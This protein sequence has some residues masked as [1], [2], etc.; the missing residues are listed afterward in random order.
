MTWRRS[1]PANASLA[2]ADPVARISSSVDRAARRIRTGDYPDAA[3]AGIRIDSTPADRFF[4]FGGRS[5]FR[6]LRRFSR[7]P[8]S[9]ATPFP[10][11]GRLALRFLKSSS[12]NRL[13]YCHIVDPHIVEGRVGR[14]SRD[15]MDQGAADP[16]IIAVFDVGNARPGVFVL[17]NAVDKE[18]QN[19]ALSGKWTPCHW[20][21]FRPAV[22]L[23][24]PA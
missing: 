10:F 15:V 21:S 22:L 1:F 19:G 18:P 14:K 12:M 9:M 8:G 23:S 4:D 11:P 7:G 5:G 20:P 3:G 16:K 13:R 2:G 17:E 24:T 6:R